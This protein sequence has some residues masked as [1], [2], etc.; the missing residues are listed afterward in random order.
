[1]NTCKY[2]EKKRFKVTYIPVD[3]YGLVDPDEV[4]KAIT[5]ETILVTI[6]HANDEVGTKVQ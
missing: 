3:K 2:L 1:L 6:M 5:K 4:K